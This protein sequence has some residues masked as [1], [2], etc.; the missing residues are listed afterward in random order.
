[1][2]RWNWEAQ[3]CVRALIDAVGGTATGERFFI[4]NVLIATLTWDQI[5]L[6]GAHPH[7]QQVQPTDEGS[8]PPN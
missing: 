6:V 1:M 2:E 4:I 7:V 5:Q 3:R 8:P